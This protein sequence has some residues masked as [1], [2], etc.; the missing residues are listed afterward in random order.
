MKHN[1]ILCGKCLKGKRGTG[2]HIKNTHTTF[3]VFCVGSVKK[4]KVE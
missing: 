1:C 2:V 3:I 4:G